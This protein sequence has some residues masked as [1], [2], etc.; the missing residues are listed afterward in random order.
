MLSTTRGGTMRF[1]AVR[2]KVIVTRTTAAAAM[3]PAWKPPPGPKS[4]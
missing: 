1:A 2:P 3:T 4:P